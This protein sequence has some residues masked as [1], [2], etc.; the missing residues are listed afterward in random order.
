[1]TNFQEVLGEKERD[2]EEG[3]EGEEE[4]RSK[5]EREREGDRGH[6]Y[7]GAVLRIKKS[8]SLFV[9]YRHLDI[10]TEKTDNFSFTFVSKANKGTICLLLYFA[11]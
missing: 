9:I 7:E 6:K 5:R 8:L 10:E 1:M 3:K 2:R 4:M 11:F